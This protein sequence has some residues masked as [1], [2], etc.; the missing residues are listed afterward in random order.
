M[1]RTQTTHIVIHTAAWPGDPTIQDI[2]RVH[3][4]EN[5][6]NDVGYHYL[7]RKDGDIQK[8]RPEKYVGAHCRD[9]GMN[10][11]S[12]GI[13]CSGHG[14]MQPF[15]DEQLE[16]LYS[17]VNVIRHIYD[18]DIAHVIG[19]RE[20]GAAKTCPGELVDMDELRQEIEAR[21]VTPEE[22]ERLYT[23]ADELSVTYLSDWYDHKKYNRLKSKL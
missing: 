11:K 14:D 17:L 20:S 7:I 23:D 22:A 8:G 18:I 9:A 21:N 16:T 19:H 5:G 2:W 6:W 4:V 10:R 1:K 13:C 15:T 12:V 3:V